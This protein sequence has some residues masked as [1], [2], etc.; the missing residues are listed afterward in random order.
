MPVEA[1]LKALT[2]WAAQQ[3]DEEK[4]KGSIE[5]GKLADFTILS[6]DPTAIDPEQLSTLKVSETI[7]ED[8]QVYAAG[9]KRT[10]DLRGREFP[11]ETLFE[12]FR[13]MHVRKAFARLPLAYRTPMAFASIS[14]SFDDCGAGLLLP[15]LFGLT[16]DRPA[17]TAK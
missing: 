4:S 5:V 2:I 7:K 15:D 12:L 3:I 13:Q 17:M 11:S 10:D 9:Q 14:R 1:A 16:P 8:R 6:A